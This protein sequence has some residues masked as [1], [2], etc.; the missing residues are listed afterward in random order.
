[1][2][3]KGVLLALILSA[4]FVVGSNSVYA[5]EITVEEGKT[6]QEILDATTTEAGD[7]IVIPEG[8][9]V[10]DVT[11][12]K[13]ITLKG[14]GKEATIIKGE[15]IVYAN[16]TVQDL[17][18][19]NKGYLDGGIKMFEPVELNVSNTI[20]QYDGY[21]E[22]D[23]GTADYFTGIWMKV[24]SS[25]S[26]VNV[27]NT[28]FY[29]KYGIHVCGEENEVTIKNSTFTGFSSVDISNGASVEN[30]GSTQN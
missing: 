9:F 10:G 29:A 19:S 3:R 18:I 21:T 14:S 13:D 7:V 26:K 23:Y 6:I 15:V 4:L 30:G 22:D 24:S 28:D 17:T 25:G 1:M 16:T 5:K 8:E 12:E 11:I 27:E 20:I 2:K